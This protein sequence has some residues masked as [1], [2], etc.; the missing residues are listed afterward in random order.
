MYSDEQKTA[1]LA[2]FHAL[3][4]DMPSDRAA[5]LRVAA[6]LGLNS[7]TVRRWV[8]V[9]GTGPNRSAAAPVI[10]RVGSK[11]SPT[12]ARQVLTKAGQGIVDSTELY[13]ESIRQSIDASNFVGATTDELHS[14]Y[15]AI[16]GA[17]FPK[18]STNAGLDSTLFVLQSAIQ[19]KSTVTQVAFLDEMLTHLIWVAYQSGMPA[20][21]I[22]RAGN[23][24]VSQV[25]HRIDARN[26]QI[27]EHDRQLGKS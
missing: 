18:Q 19:L 16:T 24:T 15:K 5:Y 17:D 6:D 7:D 10:E 12:S 11:L 14:A 20:W 4:P 23:L 9:D 1:A 22:A 8:K 27:E 2:K 21:S 25:R 26:R 13:S 3:R